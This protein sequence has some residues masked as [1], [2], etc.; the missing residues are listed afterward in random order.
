MS[1]FLSRAL[2]VAALVCLAL[3]PAAHAQEVVNIFETGADVDAVATG[4]VNLSGLT[5]IISNTVPPDFVQ[6]DIA[7]VILG[8]NGAA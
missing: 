5:F 1:R 2:P 3:A 4:S 6:G 8:S 7:V